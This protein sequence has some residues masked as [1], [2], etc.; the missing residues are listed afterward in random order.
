MKNINITA[1]ISVVNGIVI[2]VTNKFAIRNAIQVNVQSINMLAR[3]ILVFPDMFM[4]ITL[5]K[6]L[7]NKSITKPIIKKRTTNQIRE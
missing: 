5:I 1:E 3:K 6:E 4:V 2:D 7:A